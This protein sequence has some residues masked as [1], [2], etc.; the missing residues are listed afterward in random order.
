MSS[1]E[2]PYNEKWERCSG[3]EEKAGG[4]A[5]EEDEEG[6]EGKLAES[7]AWELRP[8]KG[9]VLPPIISFYISYSMM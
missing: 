8:K 9:T 6:A 2:D 4:G 5:G 7:S 1:G 3:G